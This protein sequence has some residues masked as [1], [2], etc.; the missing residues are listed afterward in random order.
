MSLCLILKYNSYIE[1]SGIIVKEDNKFLLKINVVPDQLQDILKNNILIINNRKYKYDIEKINENLYVTDSL[2]N[3]Q[4][5]YLKINIDKCYQKE[6]AI[7][8]LKLK[9]KE[10][11]IISYFT[12]YLLRKE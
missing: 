10:D 5:L 2:I 4:I 7:I 1:T 6:N 3:Y 11:K 8:K 9:I 12:N